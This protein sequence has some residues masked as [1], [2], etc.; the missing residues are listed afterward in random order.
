LAWLDAGLA[1]LGGTGITERDKLAGAVAAGAFD[2]ADDD[3][4]AEFRAG[5]SQLL[6]G[7]AVN[8]T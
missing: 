3:H 6:D 2:D 7:I 4:L 8:G 1:A 5:L